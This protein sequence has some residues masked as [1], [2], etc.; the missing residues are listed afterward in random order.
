MTCCCEH[1]L[2]HKIVELLEHIKKQGDKIMSQQDD[3]DAAIKAEDVTI[4]AIAASATKIASDVDALLA[5]IAG[6]TAPAD[7]T[8]EIQAVQAHTASL[9]A[10]ADQ[11]TAADQK[12]NP[13]A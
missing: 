5:K 11:L 7:L 8:T 9:Q 6:G 1:Q 12:A 10:A 13:P 4:Q 3:L 2:L